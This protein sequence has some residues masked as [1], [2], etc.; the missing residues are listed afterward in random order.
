MPDPQHVPDGELS[1]AVLLARTAAGQSAA[2]EAFVSRHQ[3]SVFRFARTQV[4]RPDAAEDLLQQT[5]LSAWQAAGAFRGDGSARA[6]LF[7]ITRHAGTRW[8]ERDTRAAIDDTPVD[9]LGLEAGWGGPSPERQ[10]MHRQMQACVTAALARLAPEDREILTLRDLEGLSGDEAAALLGVGTA[11]MK[12]RLHRAR[13]RLAALVR[14]G[15]CDA[16]Q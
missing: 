11:A 5:F 4:T 3:A 15:G 13:L 1:D 10:A 6:W 12:S 8:R 14:E 16:A 9:Q 2:F 7:T